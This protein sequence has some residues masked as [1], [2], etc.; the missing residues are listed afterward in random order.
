MSTQPKTLLTPEEYLAIEREAE[1]KSDY[2]NGEMFA[3]AGAQ[4]AHNAIGIN[5]SGLL[6]M[7][8]RSRSCKNYANDMRVRTASS[9]YTYPDGVV[10][11]GERRFLDERHDTLLNP[12]LIVEVLSPSTERY[13]RGLKFEQYRRIESLR[14]Y[15]M[16]ASDR[17]HAELFTKRPSGEW[18]LSEWS[19]PEDVVPLESCDCRLKLADV[20]E[21]VE[22]LVE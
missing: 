16:L 10:V 14:E 22:F 5:I 9:L 8:L 15:L 20:Y 12:N 17:I 2:W 3:M 7:Q 1:C 4:E 6:W 13:D 19:A 18:A 21:K 11:C